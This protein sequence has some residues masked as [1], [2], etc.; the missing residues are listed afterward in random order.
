[1]FSLAGIPPLA[2]FMG[3]FYIFTSAIKSGVI[4]LAIVGVI[5]SVI[6]CYYYMRV[7]IF[8]YFK[9]PEYE[10]TVDMKAA[11]FIASLIAVV[12]VL[13]I[14]VFPSFFMN[15]VKYMIV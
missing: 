15:I 14:G 2:G 8:M 9:E 11:S 7:T 4:W 6:A 5:N 12:F 13:V 10:V 1:M 3:K